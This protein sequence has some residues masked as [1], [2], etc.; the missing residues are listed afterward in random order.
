MATKKESCI[1]T[2]LVIHSLMN[3]FIKCRPFHIQDVYQR[4]YYG[5]DIMGTYQ[6]S[7]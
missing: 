6:K 7:T 3:A 1:A 4:N 5:N 2:V